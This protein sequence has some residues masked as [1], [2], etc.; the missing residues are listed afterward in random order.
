MFKKVACGINFSIGLTNS[1]KLYWWGNKK[2]C[3]DPARKD[4][5]ADEP[6]KMDKLDTKEVID[7]V[8]NCKQ[9]VALMEDG[10]ISKWGAFLMDKLVEKKE[11]DGSLNM[12]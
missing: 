3:G 8:V 10:S 12:D 11:K 7:I 2:Y 5:D 1:N 9:C 6:K 4:G